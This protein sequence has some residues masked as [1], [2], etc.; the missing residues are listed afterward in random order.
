M[1]KT[2]NQQHVRLSLPVC[3]PSP[4]VPTGDVNPLK[5]SQKYIKYIEYEKKRLSN[6]R[7]QMDA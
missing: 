4:L 2:K 6:V 5:T 1:K 7:K 3:A